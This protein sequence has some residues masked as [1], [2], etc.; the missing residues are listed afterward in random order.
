MTQNPKKRYGILGFV[1]ALKVPSPYYVMGPVRVTTTVVITYRY[2]YI[3]TYKHM[4][5]YI[6]WYA[7]LRHAVQK[8]YFGTMEIAM[9]IAMVAVKFADKVSYSW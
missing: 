2:T 7:G 9:E 8:R 1:S 6:R 5:T 3:Q 4:I